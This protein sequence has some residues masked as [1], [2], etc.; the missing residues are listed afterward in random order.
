MQAPVVAE[1]GLEH[2]GTE[3]SQGPEFFQYKNSYKEYGVVDVKVSHAAAP[4]LVW[5]A[6]AFAF[7]C[8]TCT[9]LGAYLTYVF[10]LH[11]RCK[12]DLWIC[13]SLKAADCVTLRKAFA[14]SHLG[15]H[16]NSLQQTTML[17]YV[18][19]HTLKCI[20]MLK[21]VSHICV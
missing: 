15:G 20:N 2:F 12:C 17:H 7:A 14:M 6:F 16:W 3:P 1:K 4:I 9:V 5:F 10:G 21:H 11:T 8:L 19:P 13:Y 18:L